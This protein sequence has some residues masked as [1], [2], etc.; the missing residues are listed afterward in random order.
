MQGQ[1]VRALEQFILAGGARISL[2]GGLLERVLLAPDQDIHAQSA[3]AL[4]HQL[5]DGAEPEN[6]ERRSAQSMRQR[7]RPL[8]P[9]HA[10]GFERHVTAGGDD[11]G[12]RQ[13]GR[14]IGR[15][16]LAGRHR[17]AER[18]TGGKVDRLRIA[19]DQRDQFELRQ[20]LEQRAR[21]LHPLPDRHDHVGIAQAFDQRSQIGCR[22]PIAGDVVMVDERET[23][24]LIDHVLVVVGNDNLH[25]T[26]WL[27]S[28]EGWGDRTAAE[29]RH[30]ATR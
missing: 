12:Q 17:N 8:A 5:S 14:R 25:R 28:H 7:A 21:K 23:R 19:A 16:T 9:L 26:G 13:F 10:L 30:T 22:L 27:S 29:T 3:S 15:I 6:A 4:G 1:H 18:G 20:L 11:Q 2:G 24:E